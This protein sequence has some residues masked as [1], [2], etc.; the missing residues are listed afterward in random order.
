MDLA[1]PAVSP[2][3]VPLAI[4]AA[5]ALCGAIA[6]QF[7]GLPGVALAALPLLVAAVR[8]RGLDPSCLALP[9]ALCAFDPQAAPPDPPPPGP[10]RLDGVVVS[11]LVVDDLRGD[12]RCVLA[13]GRA[14]VL[15]VFPRGTRLRPGDEVCALAT[16][17]SGD[18]R[19]PVAKVPPGGVVY[20][21]PT[22]SFVAAAESIRLALHAA[23]VDALPGREGRVLAQLVLGHGGEVDAEV[24]DAHRATGLSHLLA[25]SGAHVSLL[26]AMLGALVSLGGRRHRPP[27]IVLGTVAVYGTITGL[28]PPVVRALVAFTLLVLARRS[29]RRL[30]VLAALA[31]PAILTALLAPADTLGASFA[32][33]YAAVAG[34]ALAP[35]PGPGASRRRA[36]ACALLASAWATLTTAPITLHLFGQLAPWTILATPV[37]APLVAVLLALGIAVAALGALDQ[38]VALPAAVL[39]ALARAYLAAVEGLAELP[40]AP[41]L[42]TTKPPALALVGCA[43]VGLAALRAWPDRRGVAAACL[44]LCVPHFAPCPDRAPRGLHVLDVGHGQACLLRLPGGA[45]ALVDCGSLNR[46]ARAAHAV[47]RALAPGRRLDLVV[48]TH[49]DADHTN[50]LPMLLRRVRVATLAVPDDLATAALRQA[51]MRAGARLV[52]LAPGAD[53]E[54]LAGVRVTRP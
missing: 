31:A 11:R 54:L 5:A 49:A 32:L 30:P 43:A 39:G 46:P 34:L 52:P 50:G 42:A 41:V 8:G 37:L 3:S 14:R 27:W 2:R 33:S 24:A 48:L 26:A 25:V 51:A 22:R 1:A 29:G 36:L 21:R 16:L 35:L 18:G 40:G 28:D 15:A 47:A 38:P 53:V 17:G 13:R 9:V 6:P 23:L 10:A 7:L 44:A 4:A 20:V 12:V 19:M 45:V